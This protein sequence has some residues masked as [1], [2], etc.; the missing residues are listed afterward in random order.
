MATTI[1]MQYIVSGLA[2]GSVYA[3][4]AVGYAMIWKAMGILNFSQGQVFMLGGFFGLTAL[5]LMGSP[6][7]GSIPVILGLVVF[8]GV[9]AIVVAIM[10]QT[11]VFSPIQRRTPKER[12]KVNMLVSTM[13]VGIILENAARL[14]W[15]SEPLFFPRVFGTRVFIFSGIAVPEHYVRIIG[16]AVV[17]VALLQ[18]LMFKTKMGRAMRAI[19]QD[20]ETAALMGV[21]VKQGIY[22][23]LAVTYALGALAGTLVA[24]LLY[25]S[26][27]YGPVFGLK[28]FTA[29]VVGGIGTIPGA[30]LGGLVLGVLENV[31]AGLIASTY[32]NAIA[33]VI[34]IVVLL[35]KPS[36]ILGKRAV[37]KV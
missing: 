36:G 11:L 21:N 2:I 5:R 9:S 7:R 27:D 32:K 26:F 23:T 30:I 16:L 10:T 33:F 13:A 35:V 14:I 17:L 15:T 4:I 18:V 6:V 20:R 28:G 3:L 37:E 22:T 31:G 1:L 8:V 29:A 34:L 12:F 25:V 24:P 19:A